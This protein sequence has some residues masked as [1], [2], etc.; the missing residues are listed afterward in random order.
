[1]SELDVSGF[2]PTV[3]TPPGETCREEQGPCNPRSPYRTFSGHCNNLER[4]N[5]GKC[6]TTF[7]RL[8]PSVYENSE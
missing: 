5:L 1:M 4:P 3:E 8:L 6:L 2:I 7:A